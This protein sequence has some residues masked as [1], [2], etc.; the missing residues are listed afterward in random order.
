MKNIITKNRFKNDIR[1]FAISLFLRPA[2]WS[3]CGDMLA[4]YVYKTPEH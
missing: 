4:N 3:I 1:I 2:F